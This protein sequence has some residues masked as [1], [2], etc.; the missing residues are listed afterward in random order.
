MC[1]NSNRGTN[2]PASNGQFYYAAEWLQDKHQVPENEPTQHQKLSKDGR[3][4]IDWERIANQCTVGAGLTLLVLIGWFLGVTYERA[5]QRM[6]QLQPIG[7]FYGEQDD[8]KQPSEHPYRP[9]A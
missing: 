8:L 4:P 3:S 6:E 7:Q 9:A 1:E 5:T 2:P